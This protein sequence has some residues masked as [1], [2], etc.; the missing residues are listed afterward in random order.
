MNRSSEFVSYDFDKTKKNRG[1][2]ISLE[3][4]L[5]T[6]LPVQILIKLKKGLKYTQLNN[7]ML[8]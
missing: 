7:K 3:K 6:F 4:I 2:N 1:G 8:T 5:D